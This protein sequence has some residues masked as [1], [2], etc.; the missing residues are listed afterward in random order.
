M[1]AKKQRSPSFPRESLEYCLARCGKAALSMEPDL[2][3]PVSRESLV[4]AMG[5]E[6]MT[7][8]AIAAIASCL[9]YGCLEKSGVG[10]V[11]FTPAY[12]RYREA[13]ISEPRNNDAIRRF[14]TVM[15]LKPQLMQRVADAC[16]ASV[17]VDQLIKIAP[18]LTA[19]GR[20]TFIHVFNSNMRWLDE[21]LTNS[22]PWKRGRFMMPEHPSFTSGEAAVM[23]G[24]SRARTVLEVHSMNQELLEEFQVPWKRFLNEFRAIVDRHQGDNS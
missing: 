21:H 24:R 14:A 2:P 16:V 23:V 4:I 17:N 22:A 11:S 13:A 3:A 20:D 19:A 6:G 9:Q 12:F 18:E 1:A 10:S 8:P 5:F 7:G 15:A